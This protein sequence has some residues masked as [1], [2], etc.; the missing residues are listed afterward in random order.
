MLQIGLALDNIG[1][2][3]VARQRVQIVLVVG[4]G[5]GAVGRVCETGRG[6]CDTDREIAD[7]VT[8]RARSKD[9][10]NQVGAGFHPA[11]SEGLP[12]VFLSA[13]DT[14]FIGGDVAGAAEPG[15]RVDE[16]TLRRALGVF[17][18]ALQQAGSRR[19]RLGQIARRVGDG[20][21][22][23]VRRNRLID[24]D[25]WIDDHRPEGRIEGE[26]E[27]V[28]GF[29][30]VLGLFSRGRRVGNRVRLVGRILRNRGT[31]NQ[32]PGHNSNRENAVSNHRL[33]SRICWKAKDGVYHGF[34]KKH[35]FAI[36]LDVVAEKFKKLFTLC[37][38]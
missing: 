12:E 4:V 30:R 2:E 11:G 21:L 35:L 15:G 16:E 38:Y 19:D 17:R 20:F 23:R 27:P 33:S 32:H 28:D 22:Y 18:V 36:V 8:C 5:R 34:A 37:C 10:Q 6:D 25:Q 7:G 24:V 29:Q 26:S 31:G 3:R 9:R 1:I 13:F 14:H